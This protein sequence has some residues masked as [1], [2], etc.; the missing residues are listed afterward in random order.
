MKS[1]LFSIKELKID[2]ENEANGIHAISIVDDPAIEVPFTY[3]KQER[4]M[5]NMSNEN[6]V[7]FSISN[8]E[9][10]IIKGL[11]LQS[12]QMIYRNDVGNGIPGYNWISRD[13]IRKLYKKYGFNR[14]LT[15]QHRDDVTGNAILMKSWLEEDDT[16]Q[17]TKWFMEYKILPTKTGEKLWNIIKSYNGEMGFSIEAIF[18]IS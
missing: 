4:H 12:G 15:F 14:S 5:T 8:E 7:L 6:M 16:N 9:K 1:N 10:R 18:S 11:V 3:F 17:K 2:E 13:T